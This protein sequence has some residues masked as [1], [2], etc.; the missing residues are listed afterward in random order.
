MKNPLLTHLFSLISDRSLKSFAA[1][2]LWMILAVNFS[3]SQATVSECYCLNNAT[4]ASNGQFRDEITI[5]TGVPG[6]IWRL[7]SP[8]SG[9]F[10]PASLPPPATPI[11]YLI[12]TLVP[13]TGPSSGIYKLTGLRVSGGSWSARIVNAATNQ[14]LVVGSSRTC[15]YPNFSLTGDANV[16]PG[17]SGKVYS[18]GAL[19][20]GESYQGSIWTVS[21]GTASVTPAIPAAGSTS[22]TLTWGP[23]PGRY[24]LGVSGTHQIFTGQPLGCN[25]SASKTVDITNVSAYTTITGDFGNCIGARNLQ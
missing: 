17:A 18:L 12:N 25:F 21:G 7:Q 15:S 8:I 23:T 1:V 9:F 4:T 14:V 6:Q 19:P 3:F 24:S 5:N 16:C 11:P 22:V 13:E 2:T 20:A 10:N